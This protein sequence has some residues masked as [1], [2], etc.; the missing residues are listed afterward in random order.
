LS[1]LAARTVPKRVPHCNVKSWKSRK[2]SFS[3]RNKDGCK[4]RGLSV[5]AIKLSTEPWDLRLV[6]SLFAKTDRVHPCPIDSIRRLFLPSLK[7]LLKSC[8]CLLSLSPSDFRLVGSLFA[9]T[10]RVHPC[11]IDSIH[12]LFLVSAKT[13]LY[14]CLC[15]LSLSPADFR[16]VGSVFAKTDRVHPCPIDSI[17]RLFVPS[18]K[19]LMC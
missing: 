10:D 14:L 4:H 12:R 15:F 19:T 17:H 2:Y 5:S 11:P 13:L 3:D 7:T 9:K 8:L 18:A 6:G 1:L 16:L